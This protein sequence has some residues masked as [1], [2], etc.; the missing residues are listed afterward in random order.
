MKRFIAL[1][2]IILFVSTAQISCSNHQTPSPSIITSTQGTY[3]RAPTYTGD[4]L[5]SNIQDYT[6][7]QMTIKVPIDGIEQSVTGG[8]AAGDWKATYKDNDQW[9]VTGTVLFKVNDQ[10]YYVDIAWEV[11]GD[12]V[13]C[14]NVGN[15][16]K[17]I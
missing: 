6:T 11:T 14:V 16:R 2:S 5:I 3:T 1:F 9:D 4:Q 8:F 13:K 7:P 15:A 12:H 10:T 17:N